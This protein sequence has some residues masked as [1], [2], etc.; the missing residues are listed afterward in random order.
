MTGVQTCALP[1]CRS[2]SSEVKRGVCTVDLSFLRFG[3]DSSFQNLSEFIG[4]IL[5]VVG[6]I[7]L[8]HQ[9][10]SLTLRGDS[11][12]ALTWALMERSRGSIITNAAMV[13]AILCTTA[14]VDIR[15]IIH[16]AGTDN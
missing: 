7:I 4:A 1:I 6:H 8:G 2:N 11:V 9:G 3:D 13:W 16:I 15:G 10:Q 12:T 14:D 5:G